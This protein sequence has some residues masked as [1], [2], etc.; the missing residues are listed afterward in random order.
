MYKIKDYVNKKILTCLYYSLIYPFLTYAIHV[1]GV[2]SN[3]NIKPIYILQKRIVRLITG[4]NIP[5]ARVI[6]YI[7]IQT[8]LIYILPLYFVKQESLRYM[9]YINFK[10]LNL[11]L[12]V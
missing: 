10:L 12:P 2:A 4:I 6:I 7:L 5:Q 11:C 8:E 1:W 3:S 9:T